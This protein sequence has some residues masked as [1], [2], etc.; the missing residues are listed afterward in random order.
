MAPVRVIIVDDFEP[1]RRTF[2]RFL[3]SDPRVQV[4]AEG[5]NFSDAV[6]L[7]SEVRPDLAILDLKMP[8]PP[9]FRLDHIARVSA[10]TN[11]SVL[12][13]S[14][15][16]DEEAEHLAR[17]MGAVERFDKVSLPE[18]LLPR[19]FEIVQSRRSSSPDSERAA[20]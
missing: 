15:W 19:L 4:V 20:D 3:E 11:C 1:F 16:N 18:T 9:D 10:Q 17:A 13:A 14:I 5:Q 6:K 8:A 12:A 7:I 2:R